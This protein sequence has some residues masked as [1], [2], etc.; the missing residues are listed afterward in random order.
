MP[1]MLDRMHRRK[2]GLFSVQDGGG[3]LLARRQI[4]R[5]EFSRPVAVKSATARDRRVSPKA[6]AFFAAIDE[7][8]RPG[9][10]TPSHGLRKRSL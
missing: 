2:R 3:K 4:A 8:H 6:R 9:F 1:S 10:P 7:A 5:R